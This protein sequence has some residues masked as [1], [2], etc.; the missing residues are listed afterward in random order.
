MTIFINIVHIV[1]LYY[2][3]VIQTLDV[4]VVKLVKFFFFLLLLDFSLV[5]KDFQYVFQ[6]TLRIK[7]FIDKRKVVHFFLPHGVQKWNGDTWL[8]TRSLM[9]NPS[10][11]GCYSPGIICTPNLNSLTSS[12]QKTRR[13]PRNL[14]RS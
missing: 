14:K 5:N 12:V 10:Y 3:H 7:R 8:W 6:I 4:F 9:S 11:T 13:W 2:S 1:T